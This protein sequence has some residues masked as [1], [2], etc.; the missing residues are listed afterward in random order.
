MIVVVTS[1]H[2]WPSIG[3]IRAR[4]VSLSGP[5][6]TIT[7]RI[8]AVT[9]SRIVLQGR[10]SPRMPGISPGR[11]GARRGRGRLRRAERGAFGTPPFSSLGARLRSRVPQYGHSVMYGDTSARQFLQTTKRSGPLDMGYR[12]YAERNGGRLPSRYA[13]VAE[14]ISRTTSLKSWLASK[15]IR[16][17]GGPAPRPLVFPRPS[18]SLSAPGGPA[19]GGR[20]GDKPPPPP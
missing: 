17:R 4:S 14:T 11:S 8:T 1:C 6:L 9:T 16:W 10:A 19:R 5:A 18:E 15:T 7:D 13:V 20:R 12:F 3:A 2:H